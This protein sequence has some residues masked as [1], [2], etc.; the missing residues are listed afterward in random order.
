V[1][2]HGAQESTKFSKARQACLNRHPFISGNTE[3]P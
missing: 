1:S 3:T 2:V